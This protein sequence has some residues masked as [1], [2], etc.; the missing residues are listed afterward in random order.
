MSTNI[1]GGLNLRQHCH[2]FG[3]SV[4]WWKLRSFYCIKTYVLFFPSC[5][6][7]SKIR[8]CNCVKIWDSVTIGQPAWFFRPKHKCLPVRR[9]QLFEVTKFSLQEHVVESRA[10]AFVIWISPKKINA[11]N[12][13][14]FIDQ[15]AEQTEL[16]DVDHNTIV[17][18]THNTVEFS[19]NYTKLA[20]FK[21]KTQGF[22]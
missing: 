6:E 18:T 5:V 14:F 16:K 7:G 15:Y 3:Y 22:V 8:T 19:F 12:L 13:N 1:G 10:L 9:S 21:T 2:H 11:S 17:T 20:M 4:R